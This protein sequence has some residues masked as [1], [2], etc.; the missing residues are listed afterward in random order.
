MT[1]EEAMHLL[2]ESL[3]GSNQAR[4]NEGSLAKKNGSWKRSMGY[5]WLSPKQVA[6]FMP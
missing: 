3:C 6:S 5:H 1:K 4:G 2:N